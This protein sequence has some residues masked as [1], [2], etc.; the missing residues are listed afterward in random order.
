MSYTCVALIPAR[1][2]SKRLPD[3]NIRTLAGHPTLAYTIA[4][5]MR[6]GVFHQVVVSTD[7]EHYAEVARTYGA[8]VPFLRPDAFACDTAPDIGWVR[9]ALSKLPAADAFSI[10]RPTSPFRTPETIRRAWM[11]FNSDPMVDSLR[12][13]QP[14]RE[15]PGKMWVV[16]GEVMTPLLP[17]ELDGTPWHSNQTQALPK[18]MV[19]NASLEIAWSRVVAETGTISGY[20][21]RPFLTEGYEGFDLNRPDDWD[22][23]L[24]L[25]ATGR[26]VLPDPTPTG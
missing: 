26:V 25:V 12:A 18:V 23:A 9:H 17:F 24:D 2:G 13:V 11:Q 14:V 1:S 3:K 19:Q 5:A 22:L 8:E 21:V 10:L 16:R 4:A 7:S 15:H 6:S 20:V